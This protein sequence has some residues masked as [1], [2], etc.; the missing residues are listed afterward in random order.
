[1][2]DEKDRLGDKL[3]EVEKARE[4]QWAAELDRRLLEKLRKKRKEPQA[5]AES[6]REVSETADSR[7]K[8]CPHCRKPLNPVEREGM[9]A[10]TC[11][12]EAGAWLE[13]STLEAVLDKAKTPRSF[14][15]RAKSG[16]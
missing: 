1:M 5:A 11:P 2:S 10:W 9:T 16:G 12:S 14:F 8:L 4:D 3:H 15:W 7:S 13:R 6:A